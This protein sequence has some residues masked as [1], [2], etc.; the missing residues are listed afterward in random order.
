MK[1]LWIVDDDLILAKVTTAILQ[2]STSFDNIVHYLN[3]IDA[4]NVLVELIKQGKPL[5]NSILIDINMPKVNGWQFLEQCREIE[6]HHHSRLY[7]YTSSVSVQDKV[8]AQ[9]SQIG[10][11][12]KPLTEVHTQLLENSSNS[13]VK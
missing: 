3:A 5:P 6:V 2:R 8:L 4:Y 1:T 13:S 12:V 7:I 10:Y 9:K 11:I